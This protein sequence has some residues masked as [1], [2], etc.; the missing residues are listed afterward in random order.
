MQAG[1]IVIATA[2]RQL[3]NDLQLACSASRPTTIDAR[4]AEMMRGGLAGGVY[5][6]TAPVFVRGMA[7]WPRPPRA[8]TGI[9]QPS[10]SRRWKAGPACGTFHPHASRPRGVS[11]PPARSYHKAQ[12]LLRDGPRVRAGR[13]VTTAINRGRSTSAAARDGRAPL[14]PAGP[15]RGMETLSGV[16]I[17]PCTRAAGSWGL[18][19]RASA[20]GALG[21]ASG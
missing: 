7:A 13:P 18:R 4:P 14:L 5:T 21:L 17:R 2:P 16:E 19:Y 10:I 15:D 12:R 1:E 8:E 20:S 9:S 11:F 6:L 3:G